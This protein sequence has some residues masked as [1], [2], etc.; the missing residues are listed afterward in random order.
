MARKLGVILLGA[1]NLS[2]ELLESLALGLGDEEG[3]EDA[4]EH[5]E[6]ED[7]HDVV[8]PW[9]AVGGGSTAGV[10]GA[11]GD[12]SDDS[13]N[14]ARSSRDTVGSGSVAGR[15]AFT[16]YNEGSSVGTWRIR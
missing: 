10:Q 2:S 15:E 1:W 8:E 13:A 3:G 11:E 14:L 7:L 5:E 16:W 9:G 6:S 4:D 12:L